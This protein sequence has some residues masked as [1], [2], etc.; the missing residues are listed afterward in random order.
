MVF[1]IHKFHGHKDRS[2]RRKEEPNTWTECGHAFSL[3]RP[4]NNTGQQRCTTFA[5]LDMLSNAKRISSLQE[6]VPRF[7]VTTV[8]FYI[9]C[10][11]PLNSDIPHTCPGSSHPQIPRTAE[12]FFWSL[13]FQRCY[14]LW[15][16]LPGTLWVLTPSRNTA[17]IM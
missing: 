13:P 10:S 6:A 11:V 8:L 4:P 12:L 3:C 9:R 14:Y 1:C 17:K 2:I 15:A 16:R 5:V 7:F